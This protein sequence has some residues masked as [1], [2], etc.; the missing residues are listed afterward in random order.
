MLCPRCYGTRF[1]L[2]HGQR[3]PCPECGGMGEVHCCDGLTEQPDP[4]GQTVPTPETDG[5]RT[6][7]LAERP[8]DG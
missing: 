3:V 5:G 1:V 8:S 2:V 6:C 7:P 4:T